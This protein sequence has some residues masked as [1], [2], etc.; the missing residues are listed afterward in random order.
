MGSYAQLFTQ[1]TRMMSVTL[2]CTWVAAALAGKLPEEF[3]SAATY[4]EFLIR[5]SDAYS[6]CQSY[7]G[8]VDLI[9]KDVEACKKKF[10]NLAVEKE[11]YV[12]TY[13]VFKAADLNEDLVLKYE[14]WMSWVVFHK[15]Q[16]YTDKVGLSLKDVQTCDYDDE[17]EESA[18]QEWFDAVDENDD[19]VMMFE[20][21]KEYQNL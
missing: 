16:S 6:M 4:R 13:E 9:W 18:L 3:Y 19:G 11:V 7:R 14:E 15:C 12:P 20:E 17:H 21:Y 8:K 2:L 5:Q 1:T 10:E